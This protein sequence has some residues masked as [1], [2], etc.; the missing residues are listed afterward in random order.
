MEVIEAYPSEKDYY[1]AGVLEYNF[2]TSNKSFRESVELNLNEYVRFIK[3]AKSKDVEILVFPEATLNLYFVDVREQISEY[4]VVIPD[5]KLEIAPCEYEE[6]YSFILVEL[7]KA[8][9][10][11]QIYVLVNVVEKDFCTW[12][13]D[14]CKP[15]Y[16]VQNDGYSLYNTNIVFD[17]KGRI[18]SRYRKVNLFIEPSTNDPLDQP[19]PIFETDF[20]VKFGHFICYDILFKYPARTLVQQE[21]ITNILYPTFWFEGL[22]YFIAETIHQGWAYSNNVN[23]LVSGANVLRMGTTGA[24][25]YFGR[26]RIQVIETKSDPIRKLYTAKVPKN[27]R[28]D[29]KFEE[30]QIWE[31]SSAADLLKV[32]VKENWISDYPVFFPIEEPQKT[33]CVNDEKI[34]CTVEVKRRNLKVPDGAVSYKYA[35]SVNYTTKLYIERRNLG[36]ITCAIVACTGDTM[37]TC[38]RRFH[39]KNVAPGTEFEHIKIT[40]RIRS[41]QF[42]DVMIQPN[43]ASTGLLPFDVWR[44]TL[45]ETDVYSDLS[46][47]YKNFTI[48]STTAVSDFLVYGLFGRDFTMDY[49]KMEDVARFYEKSHHKIHLV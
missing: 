40:A 45:T 16:N 49:D 37:D 41:E 46:Y 31:E 2:F 1:T 26:K 3:L 28:A 48:E 8:A 29:F 24:G 47:T 17:R 38:G 20:G 22:S 43:T 36:E 39:T 15:P 13:S 44:Y 18:I 42:E 25:I 6:D 19:L 4:A 27:V 23:F 32:R 7:S 11:N 33:I 14:A 12:G 21:N 10:D 35:L 34:C 5:P 9:R 30:P